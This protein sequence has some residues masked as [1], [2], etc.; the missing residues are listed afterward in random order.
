MYSSC[1][2]NTL[3]NKLARAVICDFGLAKIM[4]EVPSGLT[5]SKG[6]AGTPRY[7]GPEA[8][9]GKQFARTLASDVWAWGCLFLEVSHHAA[10]I[11]HGDVY[12]R[13][14]FCPQVVTSTKPYQGI[15]DGP[16]LYLAMAK[17]T[18]PADTDAIAAPYFVKRLLH[19][20]WKIQADDRPTMQEC[21]DLLKAGDE[22]SGFFRGDIYIKAEEWRHSVPADL[23][24][25]G[26]EWRLI[27]NPA[28]PNTLQISERAENFGFQ[29]GKH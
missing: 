7:A 22:I 8:F 5:T 13:P 23:Y 9:R 29:S 17:G 26:T 4:D 6:N 11:R 24:Q 18:L 27:R 16:R 3:V 21:I 14:R 19:K 1:Q 2:A 15:P 10:A 28:V 20:I 25:E 12:Q